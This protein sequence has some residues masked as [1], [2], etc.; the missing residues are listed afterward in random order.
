MAYMNQVKKQL[1]AAAL[2]PVIPASWKWSLSVRSHMTICLT[3]SSAP[4]DLL[5]MVQRVGG[6]RARPAP[7]TYARLNTHHPESFADG[8]M[9]ETFR[10]IVAA[11][12]AGNH[13]RSDIMTDYF[14]VGHYVDL[15][16]GRWD[17]PFVC[18]ARA[19][20]VAA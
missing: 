2:K 12:N 1:I 19:D 13:D 9:L 16:L 15:Q 20:A 7:L 18:P 3:I 6:E 5:A 10:Q 4:D 8:E 14:D 11:L 17:R